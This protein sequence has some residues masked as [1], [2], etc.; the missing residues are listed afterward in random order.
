[1]AIVEERGLFWWNNQPIPKD[2]IAPEENV[3]GLLT[4]EDDGR[5]RLELDACMPTSKH[6]AV[7][8]FDRMARSST[9][10]IQ[11]FLKNDKGYV[12]LI[13]TAQ[14]GGE[15]KTH[16]VSFE[17]YMAL[18]CLVG[19]SAFRIDRK[20]P[21]LFRSIRFDM[22][23]FEDWLR[24]GTIATVRRKTTLHA[25]YKKEK[26]VTYKVPEGRLAIEYDMQ[27]PHFGRSRRRELKLTELAYLRFTPVTTL[28]LDEVQKHY[29]FVEDLLILLTASDYNLSWPRLTTADGKSHCR[30]YFLRH[31]SDTAAPNAFRCLTNFPQVRDLLGELF[32]TWMQKRELF[33]P[34]FYLY[35]GTR[36]GMNM[37]IEHRFVN[38]I[39]GLE[40]FN[41]RA[42]DTPV[43]QA[44]Q[45]KIDRILGTVGNQRDKKWL[46]GQLKYAGE[47][48]LQDRLFKTFRG[49]PLPLDEQALRKF[50][51]DCAARRNEISHF[52]GDRDG[53]TRYDTLL[54]EL[55]Q[56][57]DAL[58]ALYH[59][60]LL[61]EIGL[62]PALLDLKS[63][64][65]WPAS[66]M[67]RSLDQ[68][69]LL[70]NT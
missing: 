53:A 25:K 54:R 4:I 64:R 27:G 67:R 1:M 15:I 39:W 9:P 47:P 63:N 70:T 55:D 57:A 8:F 65:S 31:K 17:I 14:N 56:K 26:N 58:S 49:L 50:C 11:G 44:L 29:Q 46:V 7:E 62:D 40:V 59:V 2:Q 5:I 36:R 16:G 34:A 20:K 19:P 60:L 52:G 23:G 22:D 35:L 33:G 37:Y 69:G 51:N 21:Q 66:V 42:D 13:R 43:H 12:L 45:N 10:N 6:P 68:V 3:P 32:S 38:L 48:N 30:L 61:R 18:N 24:L 41:R 28:T